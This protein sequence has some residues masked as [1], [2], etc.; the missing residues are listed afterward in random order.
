MYAEFLDKASLLAYCFIHKQICCLVMRA[1]SGS[2]MLVAKQQ[3][4]WWTA[5]FMLKQMCLAD[6]MLTSACS[7][8]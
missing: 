3:F 1:S 5:A 7:L 6:S 2:Y 4:H 8:G